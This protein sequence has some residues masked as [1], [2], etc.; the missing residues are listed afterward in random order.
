MRRAPGPRRRA[1]CIACAEAEQRGRGHGRVVEADDPL[2]EACGV[3]EVRE[4]AISSAAW[5]SAA[6]AV[7][8]GV[9]GPLHRDQGAVEVEGGRRGSRGRT[10]HGPREGWRG[11]RRSRRARVDSA[12]CADGSRSSARRRRSRGSSRPRTSP[13]IPAAAV[14]HRP[15]ER[16]RGR[17]P[18]RGPARR[19]PVPLGPGPVLGD[20]PKTRSQTFNARAETLATSPLFRDAFRRRRCLVPVDGFYEW[21]RE[22][23]DAHAAADPSIPTDARWRWPGC[24]PGRQDPETGEWLRTFTIITTRPNEF[25]ARI[26]DRMPASSRPT[27]GRAGWTRRPGTRASCVALLEPRDDVALDAYAVVPARQQ[28]AQ[29]RAGRCMRSPRPGRRWTACC[30]TSRRGRSRSSRG[31]ASMAG[32]GASGSAASQPVAPVRRPRR[33]T[34]GPHPASSAA[35]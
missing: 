32:S 18:A 24:G 28:R 21:R 34:P 7:R 30:S 26:H 5:S 27:P 13:T 9:R 3:D 16:G 35:A 1:R 25:M 31:A 2:V 11:S 17:G 20:D 23:H 29:R 14:Q 4:C 33:P 8:R 6:S 15:H 12:A 19:R 10:V 22:G